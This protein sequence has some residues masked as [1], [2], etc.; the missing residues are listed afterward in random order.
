MD[1]LIAAPAHQWPTCLRLQAQY[2]FGRE[3][4]TRGSKICVGYS[5]PGRIAALQQIEAICKRFVLT[6]SNRQAFDIA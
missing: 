3:I 1:F 5:I 2:H 4:T 6:P